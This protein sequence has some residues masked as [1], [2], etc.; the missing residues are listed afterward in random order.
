MISSDS[1]S[2]T[3]HG[4]HISLAKDWTLNAGHLY[5]LRGRLGK[6]DFTQDGGQRSEEW[7]EKFLA[8]VTLP[9]SLCNKFRFNPGRVLLIIEIPWIPSQ[10][11]NAEDEDYSKFI[12]GCGRR[13]FSTSPAPDRLGCKK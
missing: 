10:A 13:G 5:W 1:P 11:R 9:Q 8:S 3:R 7:C 6:A 2:C 4:C 12:C